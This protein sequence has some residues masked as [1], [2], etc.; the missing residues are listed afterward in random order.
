MSDILT[1]G[2]SPAEL[3]LHYRCIETSCVGLHEDNG[4]GSAIFRSGTQ[5]LFEATLVEV[6]QDLQVTLICSPRLAPVE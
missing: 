1:Q 6:L 3:V 2:V 4:V 5:N